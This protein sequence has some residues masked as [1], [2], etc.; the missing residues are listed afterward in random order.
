MAVYE[1]SIPVYFARFYL[2]SYPQQLEEDPRLKWGPDGDLAVSARDGLGLNSVTSE[3]HAHVRLELFDSAAD[4]PQEL[5]SRQPRYSFTSSSN[6]IALVD[7]ENHPALEV[8]AP[9]AGTISCAVACE[10]REDT[11]NARHHEQRENIR[12]IERWRIALW[13]EQTP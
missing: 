6:T 3:H 1:V 2:V 11:Y 9:A 7:T 4:V 13:P 10:G 12:D 5:L 8:P